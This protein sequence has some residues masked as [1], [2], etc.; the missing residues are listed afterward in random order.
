MSG[1]IAIVFVEAPGVR[2]VGMLGAVMPLAEAAR[3]VAGCTEDVRDGGFVQVQARV[4]AQTEQTK[5]LSNRAP[6]LAKES[7]FGV[8]RFLLP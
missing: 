1:S 7:M 6:S 3:G 5:N 4:G 8:C 2:V